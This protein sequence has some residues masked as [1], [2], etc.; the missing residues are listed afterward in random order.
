M[1]AW[2]CSALG[3]EPRDMLVDMKVLVWYSLEARTMMAEK[4][5]PCPQ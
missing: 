2:A 1:L 5:M 3:G 4:T